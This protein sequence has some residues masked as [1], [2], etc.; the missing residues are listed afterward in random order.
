MARTP[1]CICSEKYIL[2]WVNGVGMG[3]AP[4]LMSHSPECTAANEKALDYEMYDR[5][6]WFTQKTQCTHN[7]YAHKAH[8]GCAGQSTDHT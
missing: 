2:S 4:K 8:G 7:G 1:G 6:A 5:I 3:K